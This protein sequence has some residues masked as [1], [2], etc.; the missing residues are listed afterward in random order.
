MRHIQPMC[1]RYSHNIPFQR[2]CV[3]RYCAILC[4]A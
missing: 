1:R 2:K 4:V 3:H